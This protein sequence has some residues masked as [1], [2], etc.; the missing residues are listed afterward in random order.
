MNKC[1]VSIVGAG[2]KTT[3]MFSLARLLGRSAK[4]LVTTTTKIYVPDPGQYDHMALG[5]SNFGKCSSMSASGIYVYG[6]AVSDDGK[7]IG[8]DPA[9]VDTAAPFFDYVLVE[10]DGAKRKLLKGWDDY[11]PVICSSTTHTVGVLNLNALGLTADE[12]SVHRVDQFIKTTGAALH[13]KITEAHLISLIYHK[14][15]LFK[16]SRGERIVYLIRQGGRND[17]RDNYGLRV[18]PKDG[19][20]QAPPAV[21]RQTPDRPCY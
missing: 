8:L 16:N 18:L 1:V 17:K 3:L 12:E 9:D 15:G 2:G 13:E 7:L 14:N 20:E 19:E 10:S 6:R 4:V 21:P 5:N 11:E